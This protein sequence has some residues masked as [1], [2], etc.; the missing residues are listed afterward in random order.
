MQA[1]ILAAGMGKRLGKL[2][3]SDTKCM[4]EVNGVRL[5]DSA[6][7]AIQSAGITKLG[8]VI[9]YKG[10]RVR[11]HLAS[12]WESSIDITYI[13]NPDFET[14][15]N[16]YSLLLA[17]EFLKSDD[18][19]LLESDLI[20]EPEVIS[21]L[22]NDPRDNVV[23]VDR[24]ETWMDGT[25]I[26]FDENG[27]VKSFIS[28]KNQSQIDVKDYFKTVNIYKFSASFSSKLYVPFLESYCKSIG[29]NEYYESVLSTIANLQLENL[30][31]LEIQPYMWQEIDDVIDHAN[32]STM[33]SPAGKLHTAYSQR[34]GGYWRFPKLRDFC[35]LVNPYFPNKEFEEILK[36]EFSILLSEY[37]SGLGVQE[38]MAG[39]LFKIDPSYITVGNGASELIH[40]L[41]ACIPTSKIG[42]FN[43]SFDEYAVRFAHH[44]LIPIDAFGFSESQL[45][46]S[47]IELSKTCDYVLLV[48]PD[49]PT[50]RFIDP[51]EI[52]AVL[53]V[54]KENNCSLILD[55][56]FVDF[57]PLFELGTMLSNEIISEHSNLIIVKS[58]SKS[59]GV[60]GVRLGVLASNDV[61]LLNRIRSTLP[62]WNINSFAEKFLQKITYFQNEYWES[63]RRLARTREEFSS[64][65]S[66]SG[67]KV[68]RSAAN[69]LM[70]ELSSEID[71]VHFCDFMI[72]RNILVKSLSGKSG[73]PGRNFLRISIKSDGENSDFISAL[74]SYQNS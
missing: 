37:P 44:E 27:I 31:A 43:P 9:G 10:Q 60:A 67:T 19:I 35:Y 66:A 29:L 63:C 38:V 26:S 2:T 49:N 46:A 53:P 45:I 36:S 3:D 6:L 70:V 22:V 48:N 62:V 54:L 41:G 25:V 52:L 61:D 39:N 40:A 72:K 21:K 12:K 74:Q 34:Y 24:F 4:L 69:F 58:I 23:L 8:I 47:L 17:S 59:Y 18:T 55:E 1:L 16:I 11:E 5:I 28:K 14:T 20:F 56:S 57:S 42:Y 64:K 32:A 65:L 30:S 51:K 73:I 13:V 33:F 7:Q 71:V 15:N 50:G 68:W